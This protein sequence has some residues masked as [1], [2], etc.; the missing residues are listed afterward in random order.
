MH[1]SVITPHSEPLLL[2]LVTCVIFFPHYVLPLWVFLCLLEISQFTGKQVT[3]VRLASNGPVSMETRLHSKTLETKCPPGHGLLSDLSFKRSL[4]ESV[5][6]QKWFLC[7]MFMHTLRELC[8]SRE[9]VRK[10]TAL[11]FRQLP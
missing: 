4:I 10:W 11:A 5:G 7:S 9:N 6:L 2:K 3:R 1:S 8:A